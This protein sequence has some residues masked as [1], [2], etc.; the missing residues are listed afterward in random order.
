MRLRSAGPRFVRSS[1]SGRTPCLCRDDN[2]LAR[3]LFMSGDW[4]PAGHVLRANVGMAR[5]PELALGRRVTRGRQSREPTRRH[6]SAGFA[7]AGVPDVRRAAAGSA[8]AGC[9]AVL[10]GLTVVQELLPAPSSFPESGFASVVAIQ[11][12][13]KQ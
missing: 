4:P 1:A 2:A 5:P 3:L 12:N 6:P 7:L 13:G 9:C 8:E 10:V 11:S